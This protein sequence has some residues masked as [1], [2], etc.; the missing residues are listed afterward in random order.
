MRLSRNISRSMWRGNDE[1][2]QIECGNSMK[3]YIQISPSDNVAVA[4]GSLLFL[5]KGEEV[6][7]AVTLDGGCEFA[8]RCGLGI[9]A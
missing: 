1:K 4:L 5:Y 7:S 8:L 9:G 3:Q 6:N 2:K